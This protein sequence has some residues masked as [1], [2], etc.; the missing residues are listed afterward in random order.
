M[1]VDYV[2]CPY[3]GYEDFNVYVGYSRTCAN[4]DFYYCPMC[5]KETSNVEIDEP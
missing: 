2:Y 4:G 1:D 3:C 5:G